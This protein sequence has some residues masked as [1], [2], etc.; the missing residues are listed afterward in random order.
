[1][2]LYC[3][4]PGRNYSSEVFDLL[5]EYVDNDADLELSR[6][7]LNYIVDKQDTTQ[8][9]QQLLEKLLVPV[10][11]KNSFLGSQIAMMLGMIEER[12]VDGPNGTAGFAG[13]DKIEG[14]DKL[15]EKLAEE[16]G[17][18]VEKQT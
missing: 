17:Y 10:G 16:K 11:S 8:K 13:S 14:T 5:M 3:D 7:A 15:F 4:I 2:E 1:M 9:R 6:K 18:K 12:P